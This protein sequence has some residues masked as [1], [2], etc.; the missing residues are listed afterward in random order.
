MPIFVK[1]VE[2]R[3]L[4]APSMFNYSLGVAFSCLIF[5][6]FILF[7]L[8]FILDIKEV[9]TKFGQKS[10]KVSRYLLTSSAFIVAIGV[11]EFALNATAG[12][13]FFNVTINPNGPIF[14]LIVGLFALASLIVYAILNKSGNEK[15]IIV[16]EKQ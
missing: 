16:A 6:C 13:Y 4:N 2:G 9:A 7:A 10:A 8:F 11:F 1:I 14:I 5:L 3:Y 15:E 12:V